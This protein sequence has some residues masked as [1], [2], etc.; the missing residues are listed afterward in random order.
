MLE[1]E[2]MWCLTQPRYCGDRNDSVYSSWSAICDINRNFK[3]YNFLIVKFFA[4]N[5][6]LP[7]L[8]LSCGYTLSSCSCVVV[9]C[10]LSAAATVTS[11]VH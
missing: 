6:A 3:V 7:W 10:L 9:Q 1:V 11:K 5:F 8:F 4:I 2:L